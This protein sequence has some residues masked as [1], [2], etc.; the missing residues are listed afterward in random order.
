MS[1]GS[2]FEVGVPLFGGLLALITL[3]YAL[4]TRERRRTMR[5]IREAVSKEGWRF[6]L[7]G[8]QGNPTAFRIDGASPEGSPLDFADERDRR[9]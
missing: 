9:L 4:T 1:W 3:L 7:R 8:W 6:R 2:A 5:E